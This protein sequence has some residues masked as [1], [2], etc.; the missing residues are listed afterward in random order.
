VTYHSGDYSSR[1]P[2]PSVRLALPISLRAE[3]PKP[4]RKG[5]RKAKPTHQRRKGATVDA[6]PLPAPL[7]VSDRDA[8]ALCGLGRSTWWRLH[9][10][11]KTPAAVKLG[12]SVRWNRAELEA[13]IS[14]GCPV[15]RECEAMRANRRFRAVP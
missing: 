9:S 8:A 3:L 13:W 12:R 4:C 11:G 6:E 1:W 7:L 2:M 10:A 14:A 5:S 15:R